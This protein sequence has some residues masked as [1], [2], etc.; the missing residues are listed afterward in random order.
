MRRSWLAFGGLLAMGCAGGSSADTDTDTDPA[1]DTD[2]PLPTAV[3]TVGPPL[4]TANDDLVV[5]VQ[6]PEAPSGGT[7]DVVVSW[8]VVPAV[9]NDLTTLTDTV[10]AAW[11]QRGQRWT[12]TARVV[13]GDRL[14]PPAD[15]SVTIENAAPSVSGT[16]ATVRGD[17]GVGIEVTAAG[18]D[19]DGD[20]LVLRYRWVRNGLRAPSVASSI[21]GTETA[22]GEVW[23][24]DVSAFDGFVVSPPLTL[25]VTIPNEPPVV[26]AIDLFPANPRSGDLVEATPTV[27]DPDNELPTWTYAWAVDGVVQPSATSFGFDTT[28]LSAGQVVTVTVTPFDGAGAGAPVSASVTLTN[29]A[30]STATPTLSPSAVSRLDVLACTAG[31]STDP[32]GDD[33]TVSLR[34]LA[35]GV[36][37]GDGASPLALAPYPRGTAITCTATPSDGTVTGLA[38]SSSKVVGNAA[39]TAT[40]ALTPA[41]PDGFDTVSAI[42]TTDDADADTVS[43]S[44]AWRLNGVDAGTGPTLSGFI[45]GD[46]IEATLTFSDGISTPAPLTAGPLLVVNAPPEV[47]SVSISPSSPDRTTDLVAS[48]PPPT[49]IDGDAAVVRYVWYRGTV[50]PANQL[51]SGPRLLAGNFARGDTVVV[52]ATPDDGRETGPAVTASVV[53]GDAPGACTGVTVTP[54]APRAADMITFA[55]TSWLDPDG[56]PLAPTAAWVYEALVGGTVVASSSTIPAGTV[57]AGTELTLRITPEAAPGVPAPTVSTTVTL[58]NTPPTLSGITLLPTTLARAGSTFSVVPGTTFDADGDT[59]S[60]L[61][62]WTVDGVVAGSDPTLPPPHGVRGN[63]VRVVVTPTDGIAQG[64]PRSASAFI[65][66]TLP[67]LSGV[68]IAPDPASTLDMLT[69]TPQGFVDPDGDPELTVVSWE[70]GG[71]SIASGP[72]L[73]AGTLLRDELVTCRA[74]PIDPLGRG[75]SVSATLTLASAPP[76]APVPDIVAGPGALVCVVATPAFDADGDGIVYDVTWLDGLGAPLPTGGTTTWPGDTLAWNGSPTTVTCE[77]T[78]SDDVVTGGTGV[79]TESF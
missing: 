11:T 44:V 56:D 64:A 10:P 54:P 52:V 79:V 7:Y 45:G 17:D 47:A 22:P 3:V 28:G 30:P 59:V 57:L 63:L 36:D 27:V 46:V 6:S 53:I 42:V 76:S 20:V 66:N 5:S 43:T 78:A 69:C 12:A 49:D 39:P 65:A 23:S 62:E 55:C 16:I 50:D 38:T 60:L 4:P 19:P 70:V 13:D 14:G 74:Q 41:A 37:V 33:V 21:P 68:V 32:D 9:A 18:E 34:W 31:A 2:L 67:S 51:G 58:Q 8:S 35:D 75:L 1:V 77:L 48:S 73:P 72:T 61:Y 29:A 26:T 24:V 71:Q 15:A 40:L 25:T